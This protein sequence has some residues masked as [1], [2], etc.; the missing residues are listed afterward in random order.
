[1]TCREGQR[2]QGTFLNAGPLRRRYPAGVPDVVSSLADATV[3][4]YVRTFDTLTIEL[5]LWND[6]RGV[7][8]AEGVTHLDDSGTHQCDALVRLPELDADGLGIGYAILNVEGKATLRFRAR[9]VAVE[10]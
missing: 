8:R 10:A 3:R 1:M 7:V 4:Q 6:Q 2:S 5:T 9:H